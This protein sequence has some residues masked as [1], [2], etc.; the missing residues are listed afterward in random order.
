L[1]PPE[2]PPRAQTPRANSA[3][4]RHSQRALPWYAEN[5]LPRLVLCTWVSYGLIMSNL[6]W[7]VYIM[8]IGYFIHIYYAMYIYI[9]ILMIKSTYKYQY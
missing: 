5:S 9:N 4:L 6:Y 3:A 2:P 7:S 1:I 8:C